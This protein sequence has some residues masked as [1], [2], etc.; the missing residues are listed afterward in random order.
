VLWHGTVHLSNPHGKEGRTGMERSSASSSDDLILRL[1][2]VAR[3]LEDEGQLNLAKLFRAAA[4][5]ENYRHTQDRPR[6]GGGL[7]EAMRSAVDDLSDRSTTS[8][9][10]RT[11]M[12]YAIEAFERGE[13]PMPRTRTSA[14]P[15]ERS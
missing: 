12:G 2:A 5:G 3:G 4:A 9:S 1:S 7:E 15:A 13:W 10:L 6:Q 11:A 8:K 14:G